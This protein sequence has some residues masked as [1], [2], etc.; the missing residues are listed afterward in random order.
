M[1]WAQLP[2]MTSRQVLRVLTR[3]GWVIDRQSGSHVVLMR[4][5]GTG[6][7]VV[8]NHPGDVNPGT[9]RGIFE[10]AG[11]SPEDVN[12]LRGK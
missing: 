7:V 12:R 9:L 10:Q 1:T 4:P 11:L 6:R 3:A 8:P 5:D 2:A